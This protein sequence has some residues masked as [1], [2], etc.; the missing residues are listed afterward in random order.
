LIV[1]ING[2]SCILMGCIFQRVSGFNRSAMVVQINV[3]NRQMQSADNSPSPPFVGRH[4][5]CCF[6]WW[7]IGDIW[8]NYASF[9][10][11]IV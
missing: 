3:F 7:F 11:E 4:Q 8:S 10:D 1:D 2:L 6:I 9:G 5:A